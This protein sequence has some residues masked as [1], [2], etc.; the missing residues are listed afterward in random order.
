MEFII[1]N[2]D[3]QPIQRELLEIYKGA[4]REWEQ[5]AYRMDRRI[6]DYFKW[7][8]KRAPEGFLV[9]FADERPIGFIAVDYHW[10]DSNGETIGE[11]HEL[12]VDPAFQNRGVGRWLLLAGLGVLRAKGHRKFRLWVGKKN[13]K[14]QAFYKKLGFREEEHWSTWVRMLREEVVNH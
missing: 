3:L 13:T 10:I 1:R 6:L 14:A 12:A 7:L 2:V 8:R 4:Y 9:A 11:I 5:Y